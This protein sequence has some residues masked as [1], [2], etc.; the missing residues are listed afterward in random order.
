[1]EGREGA[2]PSLKEC[3]PSE[4]HFTINQNF[5]LTQEQDYT[6]LK[7]KLRILRTAFDGI[8]ATPRELQP[9]R[10][11]TQYNTKSLPNLLALPSIAEYG[12]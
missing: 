10:L 1:M 8:Q 7:P 5:D 6:T 11:V 4:N 3:L 12:L 9:T 2:R